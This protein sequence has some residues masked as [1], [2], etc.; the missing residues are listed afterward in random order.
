LKF[1]EEITSKKDLWDGSRTMV[2][3]LK[4]VKESYYCLYAG[5]SNSIKYIL[6][7]IL[8]S[9]PYLQNI[10][11]QPIYGTDTMINKKL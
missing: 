7:A 9:S 5:G 11:S 2:D 10:Y 6:P 4:V 1:I 3:L 8:N